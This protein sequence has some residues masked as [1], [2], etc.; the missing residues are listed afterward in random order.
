MSIRI[1][2][3]RGGTLAMIRERLAA[4][5]RLIDAY[6]SPDRDQVRLVAGQ[7]FDELAGLLRDC[8]RVEL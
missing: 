6:P 4:C 5:L 2:P 8:W 1:E 7:V 3:P